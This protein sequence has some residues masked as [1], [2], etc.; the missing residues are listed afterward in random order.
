MFSPLRAFPQ[1]QIACRG[2]KSWP[3]SIRGMAVPVFY[4]NPKYLSHTPRL[5][6]FQTTVAEHT[7]STALYCDGIGALLWCVDGFSMDAGGPSP[8]SIAFL[9]P[10]PQHQALCGIA[11]LGAASPPSN[12]ETNRLDPCGARAIIPRG[13]SQYTKAKMGMVYSWV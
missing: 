1:V 6:R 13:K 12:L 9:A 5:T 10:F 8:I 7:Y 4:Q 11:S 3:R 2:L